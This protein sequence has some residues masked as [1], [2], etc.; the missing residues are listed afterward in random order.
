MATADFKY[1]KMS[2]SEVLKQLG[3]D[4]TSGLSSA[5]AAKLQ[6]EHGPNELEDEEE[7]SLWDKIKEAFDDLLAKILLLAAAISTVIAIF[8]DG[9]EGITAYVE[10]FV[11]LLILVLNAM[12]AIYQ[13]QDAESALTALKKMSTS[14]CTVRRDGVWKGMASSEL[15]PGDIVRVKMGD[16]VP[17]DCRVIKLNSLSLMIEEAPLTGESVSVYKGIKAITDGGEVLQDQTNMIFS[18]TVV[19]YGTATGVVVFTG[20]KT[21]IG[22]VQQ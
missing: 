5:Q 4:E 16:S 3:V 13:D 9:D 12:V 6:E 2:A 10:P 7:D 15:V 22:R 18:S 8:G 1:H 14:N 20:T 21:A 11:I 17:A 19:N